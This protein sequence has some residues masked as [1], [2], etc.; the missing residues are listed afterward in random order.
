MAYRNI[1]SATSRLESLIERI[2][3]QK[4]NILITGTKTRFSLSSDEFNF[5][6]LSGEGSFN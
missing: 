2:Q 3:Q 1:F 5:F 6:E 4:S